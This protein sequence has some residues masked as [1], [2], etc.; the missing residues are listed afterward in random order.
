MLRCIFV[1]QSIPCWEKKIK[2]KFAKNFS[3][4][5]LQEKKVHHFSS[6]IHKNSFGK[7]QKINTKT[8]NV[9][10][11]SSL[12]A[13]W[14]GFGC[15]LVVFVAC[16]D[17]HATT[18]TT[19]TTTNTRSWSSYSP[20]APLT[21]VNSRTKDTPLGKYQKALEKAHQEEVAKREREKAEH[22]GES[23]SSKF[24]P[25]LPFF[26]DDVVFIGHKVPDADSISS[27]VGAAY[28]FNGTPSFEGV[29]NK[30]TQFILDHFN[31]TYPQEIHKVY[32]GQHFVLVDHNAFEQR[33]R[34]LNASKIMG[35]FDHHALSTEPTLVPQPVYVDIKPWGSCASIIATKF[36]EHDR[37][38]PPHIAGLLLG[39]LLSDTLNL[40]S[41]TATIWD[42][43]IRGWLAARAFWETK[44][45][46]IDL[47]ANIPPSDLEDLVNAFA[48][49]QFQA[50]ANMTGYSR[51]KVAE[52]D[53]KTYRFK[54]KD[55]SKTNIGWGT[56]ETVEPFY[57]EYKKPEEYLNFVQN[58]MPAIKTE[59]NLDHVFLSFVDIELKRS[60]VLC[61]TLESCALLGQAY[62]DL[63]ET[64]LDNGGASIFHTTPFVSRKEEFLPPVRR[65][66]ID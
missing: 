42:G 3:H 19:T 49:K 33:V 62:T 12:K 45:G 51:K 60:F 7:Y 61:G 18:T 21:A 59:R 39:G 6:D 43:K 53:F 41:P 32:Q 26:G 30:E 66:L 29:I 46:K 9:G 58:S 23:S 28:L 48:H 15:I 11:Q 13:V 65:A 25:P 4:F 36:L 27:A 63:Q 14:L 34:V 40:K 20:A 47:G 44:K 52:S 38:I 50:K 56:I 17:F 31:I 35:I 1:N 5:F 54:T 10:R 2:K 37:I 24:L 16:V 22:G 57:S 55:G 64:K 8:M